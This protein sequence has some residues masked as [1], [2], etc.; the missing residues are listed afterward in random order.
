MLVGAGALNSWLHLLPGWHL[1]AVLTAITLATYLH[2][3]SAVV[4]QVGAPR[5]RWAGRRGARACCC[6]LR[7]RPA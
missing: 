3:V 7:R 1:A 4:Q 2:Y 6:A 5:G